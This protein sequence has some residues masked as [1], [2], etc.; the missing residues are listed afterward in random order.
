MPIDPGPSRWDIGIR[1]DADDEDLM[2]V[3]ADLEPATVLAAYRRG[4]FPMGI[5]DGG[6]PPIGWW[7]PARR[8]VLRPGEH[9]LQ[10]SLRRRRGEFT[11][12]IDERFAEV[13]AACGDP[14]R[15]GAWIT[16]QI[17]RAYA[18]LHELGWAHSV[19]VLDADGRLAGGLYGLSIGGLFAGES[20]FHRR[21]DAGKVALW[22]LVERIFADGDPRRIIDVQWQTPHLAT[23]GVREI[24]RAEYLRALPGALA[25]GGPAA[26]AG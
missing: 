10:R 12:R 19:E 8:G 14:A 5:G 7:S 6:A 1:D 24:T 4:L 11:V 18:R 23:Q 22:A 25:C 16:P 17:A 26:F 13:V 20:M 2:G 21:T 15:D 3:G 9:H